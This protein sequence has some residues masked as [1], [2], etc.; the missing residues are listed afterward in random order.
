MG[1]PP[2]KPN[3]LR[4]RVS[5]AWLNQSVAFMALLRTYQKAP[6]WKLL[7]PLL[8]AMETTA[9]GAKP[10]W[11]PKLLVMTLNSWVASEF[12]NVATVSSCSYP[13]W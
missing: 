8:V 10:Y 13:Y 6:P 1:P 7:L 3:W 11:A 12:G 2:K 5:A 4:L 9:L